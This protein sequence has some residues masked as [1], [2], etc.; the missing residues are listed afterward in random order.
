MKIAVIIPSYRVTKHIQKVI[1]ETPSCV[2]KIYVVDDNCPDHSGKF[3]EKNISDPRVKV[4]YHDKNQGV[5][6]ATLTGMLQAQEDHFDIFVK[7]DGDGQIPP[8]LIP[9]L[10]SPIEDK[11]ADFVKG[12]RFFNPQDLNQMPLAR[13]LGNSF[14][15]LLTKLTSGYWKV[16]DPTNGFIA[17]HKSS[18]AILNPNKL[19]KRYFFETDLLYRLS[20]QRSVIKEIPMKAIYAD[21]KSNMSLIKVALEFPFKHLKRIIKRVIYQY[22]LRDFNIATLTLVKGLLLLSFGIVFG[23]YHWLKS[24]TTGVIASSG[25]VMIAALSIILGLQLFMFFLQYDIQNTP[26]DPIQNL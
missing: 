9:G 15:S 22:I 21:E 4:L 7:V 11:K 20:L 1:D 6:G 12:N 13:L 3:V 26:T 18:F 25:T 24:L 16:S 14:L 2:K 8:I 19:S 23:G 17:I 5:G 10:V